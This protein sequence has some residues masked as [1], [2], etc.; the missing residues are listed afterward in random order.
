[1]HANSNYVCMFEFSKHYQV[2]L[3]C[4][5]WAINRV[6]SL[7]NAAHEQLNIWLGHT[8]IKIATLL[9]FCS[10]QKCHFVIGWNKS[11]DCQQYFY[12]KSVRNMMNL[13]RNI[14]K[15][16]HFQLLGL[17]WTVCGNIFSLRWSKNKKNRMLC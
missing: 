4:H 5:S 2:K 13:C 1:M 14:T 10:I 17:L 12:C 8:I 15:C 9:S 16:G 3:Y 11:C 6:H 7:N